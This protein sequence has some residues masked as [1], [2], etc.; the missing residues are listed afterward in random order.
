[1]NHECSKRIQKMMDSALYCEIEAA[2]EK[3]IFVEGMIESLL[4]SGLIGESGKMF[5]M[6]LVNKIRMSRGILLGS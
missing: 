4:L 6:T 3:L 5:M 2:K 1:M